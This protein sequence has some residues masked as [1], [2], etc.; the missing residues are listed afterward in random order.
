VLATVAPYVSAV[1]SATSSYLTV[2]LKAL[3]NAKSKIASPGFLASTFVPTAIVGAEIPPQ[4]P[5]DP[6]WGGLTPIFNPPLTDTDAKTKKKSKVQ[7]SVRDVLFYDGVLYVADE[8]GSAVRMYDPD[9]GVPW[10]ST[11][12]AK[13]PVH[14][15][16]HDGTLYV[17]SGNSIFSGACVSPPSNAPAAP[18]SSQFSS[19]PVPP[20]Y[21]NPPSGY[22]NSVDLKLTD[23]G[24]SLPSGPSGLAFDDLG[25]LYVALRTA[26]QIWKYVPNPKGTPPFVPSPDGPL[27]SVPDNPEFLL[28]IEDQS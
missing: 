16:V 27:F 17:T 2:L 5:V 20:P 28:W 10:G 3:Q 13:G 18:S 19:G 4:T 14:L 24:L 26:N 9:L 11:S 12:L 15:L 25:N 22:T 21:P 1:G 23:L 6:L 7:N 8:G